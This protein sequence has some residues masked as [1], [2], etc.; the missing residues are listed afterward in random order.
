MPTKRVLESELEIA[1]FATRSV[2]ESL[3]RTIETLKKERLHLNE[4][5]NQ[6]AEATLLTNKVPELEEQLKS[7][8]TQHDYYSKACSEYQ[9][10][11]S[12]IHD[13]LD[14]VGCPVPKRS[15]S[16]FSDMP[17]AVR[18][19]AMMTILPRLPQPKES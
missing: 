2:Q 7:K 10:S 4:V 17:L 19:A 5:N 13:V 12:Q 16:A 3:D 18:V 15:E 11:E 8:T 1:K 9:K 14:A 6:L